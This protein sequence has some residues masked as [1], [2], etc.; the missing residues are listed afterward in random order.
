MVTNTGDG[1][2]YKGDGN[3]I[4]SMIKGVLGGIAAGNFGRFTEVLLKL[5]QGSIET[6]IDSP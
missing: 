6:E 3:Q 1:S 5:L 2:I 4:I